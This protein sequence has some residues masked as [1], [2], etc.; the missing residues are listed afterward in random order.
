MFLKRMRLQH[1]GAFRDTGW[2]DFSRGVNLIVG[3]NNSGKSSLFRSFGPSLT[4]SPHISLDAY[5]YEDLAKPYQEM[6]LVLTGREVRRGLL[7]RGG[8]LNWPLEAPL[9]D[10]SPENIDRTILNSSPY[11]MK[12]ERVPG[13]FRRIDGVPTHSGFHGTP[14]AFIELVADAPIVR[15]GNQGMQYRDDLINLV[16][17]EWS[18]AFIF[19]AERTSIGQ[20]GQQDVTRLSPRAD[21]LPA[22]L[23]IIQ[24]RRPAIFDRLVEHVR[25]IIPTVHSLTTT[26]I[27][28]SVTRILVWPTKHMDQEA[29]SFPLADSGTGVGQV[30]AIV[31]AAMTS[32]PTIFIID[33][34]NSYLHPTAVKSLLRLLQNDYGHHQYIISTHSPEVI[35]SGGAGTVYLVKRDGMESTVHSVDMGNVSHLREMADHI[36]ISIS[37]IFAADHVLWVEGRTEELCFSLL[38]DKLQIS[39]PSNTVISPVVATG[40]FFSQKRD[41]DLVF[42]VYEKLSKVSLPLVRSVAF[43]F[44]R[45]NLTATDMADTNRRADGRVAFLP[46]RHLECYLIVPQAIKKFANE[47]DLG[48]QVEYTTDAVVAALKDKAG[49]VKYLAADRWKGDL[50]DQSWLEEVDAAKLIKDV[51]AELTEHRIAFNKAEHSAQILDAIIETDATLIEGLADYLR[52]LADLLSHPSG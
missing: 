28:E 26:S 35:S 2:L 45:E 12:F 47:A 27:G 15:S 44:D 1:F 30:V 52:L 49:D 10:V 14:T 32:E 31:A 33:E 16:Q 7:R 50:A 8:S 20:C 43:S 29:Y 40:D 13:G 22:F 9:S 19:D 18:N 51:L 48:R 4:D 3:Q 38:R 34:I 5:L 11:L 17:H 42:Q 46:R 41:I 21:N 24:G 6:E 36:G 37:D 23:R 25:S 39:F